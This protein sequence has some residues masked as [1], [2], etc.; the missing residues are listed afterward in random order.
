MYICYPPKSYLP[1]VISFYV[2]VLDS[3]L[4]LFFSLFKFPLGSPIYV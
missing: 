2:V 3:Y 1:Y 4:K